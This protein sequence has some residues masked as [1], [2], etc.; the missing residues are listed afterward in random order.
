MFGTTIATER[1][2][3]FDPPNEQQ[4]LFFDISVLCNLVG[5]LASHHLIGS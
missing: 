2:K 5:T 1:P 3:Y 4:L